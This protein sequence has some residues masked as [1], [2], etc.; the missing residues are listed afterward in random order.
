M[1]QTMKRLRQ[2]TKNEMMKHP[3]SHTNSFISDKNKEMGVLPLCTP[4]FQT[5]INQLF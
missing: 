3:V 1:R 4:S 5:F 2:L